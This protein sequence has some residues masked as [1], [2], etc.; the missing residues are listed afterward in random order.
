MSHHYLAFKNVHY[1]YPDGTKA[2]RGVTFSISHGEKVAL[3]GNNGAGKST[4]LLHTNGLLLPTDGEVNVGD[5]RVCKQTLP[6]VRQSVGLVFQNP[7]D[8]LFMPTVYDDVAFGAI[9]M[10][11][12]P[13]EVEQR[14]TS[15]L[16]AVGAS[17]LRNRASHRLSGG[18]KRTVAIATVLSMRPNILVM[19][20]PS[21][22][23]DLHTRRHLIDI[24]HS[25]S[26]TCLIATH[27]LALVQ[28]LCTRTIVM[29][30]GTIIADDDTSSILAHLPQML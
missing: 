11:L 17:H 20:E 8:Q 15:A 26:H 13:D 9:N 22:N 14:V 7:D 2:L 18:Q 6:L 28:D 10:R 25:F 3:I 24:I 29:N 4:L 12:P 5:V 21:S 30:E 19:D 16:E 23:L 27:D 1:S